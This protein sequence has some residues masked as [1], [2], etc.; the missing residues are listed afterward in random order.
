VPVPDEIPAEPSPCAGAGWIAGRPSPCPGLEGA[1]LGLRLDLLGKRRRPLEQVVFITQ[2]VQ[3]LLEL[4]RR[5][6]LVGEA[7]PVESRA[8]AAV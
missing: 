7:L 4:R 8:E 6:R 3:R 5:A 1:Q 2:L